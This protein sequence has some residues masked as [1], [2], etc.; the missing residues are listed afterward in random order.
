MQNQNEVL[1]VDFI[2]SFGECQ[3][4]EIR[5]R[6]GGYRV[7]VGVPASHYHRSIS[8]YTDVDYDKIVVSKIGCYCGPAVTLSLEAAVAFN[9]TRFAEWDRQ[10]KTILADPTRYGEFD[11]TAEKNMFNVYLPAKLDK[12][13]GWEPLFSFEQI[14]DLAGIPADR[15][16]STYQPYTPT[17]VQ[18]RAAA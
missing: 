12:V 8:N 13:N 3:S 11:V 4:F 7:E 2:S 9:K 15:S 5:M 18:G 16:K 14:R 10:I 6:S 1:G 17:G